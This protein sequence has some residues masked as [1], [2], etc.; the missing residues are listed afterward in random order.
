MCLT[1]ITHTPPGAVYEYPQR[2][3]ISAIARF[4]LQLLHALALRGHSGARRLSTPPQLAIESPCRAPGPNLPEEKDARLATTRCS[5]DIKRVTAVT[6]CY[7]LPDARALQRSSCFKSARV[8]SVRA[9][10]DQPGSLPCSIG[11]HRPPIAP[12]I[13]AMPAA[14]TCQ[15]R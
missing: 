15:R 3:G 4:S 5:S 2:V 12:C 8:S 11:V 7:T 10:S 9:V 1:P 13:S 6:L 14:E